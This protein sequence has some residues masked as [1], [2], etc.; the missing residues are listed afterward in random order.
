MSDLDI[1][2]TCTRGCPFTTNWVN[3]HTEDSVPRELRFEFRGLS[4]LSKGQN[5][6]LKGHEE[7]WELLAWTKH[8]SLRGYAHSVGYQGGWQEQRSN[9]HFASSRLLMQPDYPIPG[10]D[11]FL[12]CGDV[13]VVVYGPFSIYQ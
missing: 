3:R 2:V 9:H 11:I 4:F 1:A 8:A 12:C 7:Q 10:K 5:N 6:G 13:V